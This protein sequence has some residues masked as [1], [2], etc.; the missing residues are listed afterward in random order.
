M[1]KDRLKT[2]GSIEE[3]SEFVRQENIAVRGFFVYNGSLVLDYFTK[4]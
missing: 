1:I 2:F 3:A 4:D